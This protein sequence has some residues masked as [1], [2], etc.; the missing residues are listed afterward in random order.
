[1]SNS[2]FQCICTYEI[3]T[4]MTDRPNCPKICSIVHLPTAWQQFFQEQK[5]LLSLKC[6]LLS[7]SCLGICWAFNHNI[8]G[9][10][11]LIKTQVTKHDMGLDLTKSLVLNR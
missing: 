9:S 5:K 8:W 6:H 4:Y 10:V 1:M 11:E 7:F 3:T 2:P